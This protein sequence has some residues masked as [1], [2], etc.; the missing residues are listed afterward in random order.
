MFLDRAAE[1]QLSTLYTV[2]AELRMSNQIIKKKWYEYVR[3]KKNAWLQHE[4]PQIQA[5]GT[6]FSIIS[7]EVRLEGHLS[8]CR[9]ATPTGLHQGAHNSLA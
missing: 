2:V 7:D 9:F 1:E 3:S 4:K 6:T 8:C 5:S